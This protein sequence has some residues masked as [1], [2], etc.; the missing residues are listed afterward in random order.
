MKPSENFRR[1][2]RGPTP[3]PPHEYT[4]ESTTDQPFSGSK[5]PLFFGDLDLVRNIDN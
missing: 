4:Y 5:P 3:I 2:H 1:D